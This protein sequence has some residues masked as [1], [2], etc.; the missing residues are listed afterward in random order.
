MSR[1]LQRIS[2]NTFL[3]AEPFCIKDQRPMRQLTRAEPS[4]LFSGKLPDNDDPLRTTF[5]L[6]GGPC[7]ASQVDR[8]CRFAVAFTLNKH[9]QHRC[10]AAASG[11][12]GVRPEEKKPARSVRRELRGRRS[13][14]TI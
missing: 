1:L 13:S 11:P 8:S 6:R 3:E 14:G 10:M 5:S 2:L 7:H 9:P 4:H 12:V